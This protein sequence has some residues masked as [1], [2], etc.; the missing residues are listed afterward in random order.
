MTKIIFKFSVV[1]LIASLVSCGSD[2][3]EATTFFGGKIINPKSNHVVLLAMDKVI[4]TFYL[5]DNN[6][7]LGKIRDAK[8]GLYHFKHGL[9][10]QYIYI[11]P[12]DSLMLRL[13][14]WDFDESLVFAGKGADR[15]NILIDCFLED[16]KEN[17]MF[18]SFNRLSP[19]K[20]KL[21][22]DSLLKLKKATYQEYLKTHP[23]ETNRYHQILKIALMYPIYTRIERYPVAN[24]KYSKLADFPTI[25]ANFYSH[26][27]EVNIN[28]D[29]LMYYYP[30]SKYIS[31]YLYNST[32][33]LGHKPMVSEY[34]SRFTI[35]LLNTINQSISSSES[36]NALLKQTVIQHFYKK[37]S[38]DVNEDVFQTYF[39]LSDNENDITHVRLL[40]RDS[41]SVKKGDQLK[42]FKIFDFNN[43]KH[44]ISDIIKGKNSLIFFWNPEYVSETYITSRIKFFNNNFPRIHFIQVKIDGNSSD[45]IPELDIKNQFY[46]DKSSKANQ[47]LT[48]KMPRLIIVDK[49]GEVINGY[50]SISSRKVYKELNNLVNH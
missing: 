29:S 34:S 37:S 30:Y 14:T 22:M 48:S 25:N 45:R 47:F 12:Q 13:N 7:F 3:K 10:N 16:E 38:C 6:K 31:N 11:E 15:N 9:E 24:V 32:Y 41:K 35:D 19:E 46:I 40:L 27:N 39:E 42:G 43:S 17:K 49:K 21:K 1:F 20:F 18:Y 4:D 44:D 8:E 50:A 28:K 33:S 26:R 23:N 2:S 36:K 5:D